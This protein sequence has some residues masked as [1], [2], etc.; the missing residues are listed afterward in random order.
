MEKSELP[1]G[2]TEELKTN[3]LV[4]EQAW[5][6]SIINVEDFEY[7]DNFRVAVKGNKLE[8]D[9]YYKLSSEGCCGFEDV[10]VILKAD[11]QNY[12]I[13]YGFNYGH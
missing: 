12:T 8:E 11:D 1:E 2:W 10:E 13:M 5:W 6:S 4:W 9:N 3:F 7:D